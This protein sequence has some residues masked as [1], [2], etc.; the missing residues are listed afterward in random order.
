M[1]KRKTGKYGENRR[2]CKN[3][4][5]IRPLSDFGRHN[6]HYRE[7]CWPCRMVRRFTAAEKKRRTAIVKAIR[8][9][10]VAVRDDRTPDHKINE[11]VEQ[12]VGEAGGVRELTRVWREEIASAR[13]G[14]W[15][16]LASYEAI[17][18]LGGLAAAIVDEQTTAVDG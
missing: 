8:K 16:A 3:C 2:K 15:L 17:F 12:A 5:Q 10:V 11:L 6:G 9:I 7:T 14:S 18:A 13:P 1:N 4:G